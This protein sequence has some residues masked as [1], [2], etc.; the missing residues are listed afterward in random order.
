M[1]QIENLNRSLSHLQEASREL[2]ASA[3]ISEDGLIIASNLTMS[4]DEAKVAAMSASILNLGVRTAHELNRGDVQQL[5]IQGENGYA[6]TMKIDPQL[7]L[8]CLAGKNARL[9]YIFLFMERAIEEIR[10]AL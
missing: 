6:I 7:F 1:L 2:E 8:V 3:V 10:Q 5:Y 9:G 4:M